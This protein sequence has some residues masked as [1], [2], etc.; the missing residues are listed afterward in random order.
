MGPRAKDHRGSCMHVSP[1]NVGH[2]VA[3]DSC[4]SLEAFLIDHKLGGPV[5]VV[6]TENDH[7][8]V[9]DSRRERISWVDG[10][11]RANLDKV[12]VIVQNKSD[13]NRRT[14]SNV[15]QGAT[16]SGAVSGSGT[17]HMIGEEF[18]IIG[19]RLVPLSCIPIKVAEE[20]VG[21]HGEISSAVVARV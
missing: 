5:D 6:T 4:W 10:G 14:L 11:G 19:V 8:V 15:S 12:L 17:A 18:N 7:V 1:T 21:G 16:T 3:A 13:N 20:T 9:V 2:S